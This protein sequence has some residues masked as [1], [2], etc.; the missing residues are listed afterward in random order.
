MIHKLI[1]KIF[2][3]QFTTHRWQPAGYLGFK[4]VRLLT[5][6]RSI[7]F[8]PEGVLLASSTAKKV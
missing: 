7:F 2:E 3:D 8:V 6:L 1:P 5:I 4:Q